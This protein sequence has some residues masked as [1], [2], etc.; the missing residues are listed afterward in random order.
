MNTI[1]KHRDPDLIRNVTRL[2][3]LLE[4]AQRSPKHSSP[5]DDGLGYQ[6]L[7]LLFHISELQPLLLEV[8]NRALTEGEYT[9]IL[10]DIRIRLLPKK[11]DLANLKKLETYF[12]D[13]L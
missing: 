12:I 6:Y 1:F 10:E 8:Y 7:Q 13:Q 4:Q 3:D 5:G 2:E 9:T 11:G